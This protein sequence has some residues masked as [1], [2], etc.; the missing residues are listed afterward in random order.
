MPYGGPEHGTADALAHRSYRTRLARGAYLALSYVVAPL[1]FGFLIWRGIANRAYWERLGERFGYTR[2][3]CAEPSIWVHAVSVGEVQAAAPMV[4]ALR[5]DYPRI[6]FVVSTTT[7]TGAR[8]VADLFGDDVTHVFVP[9]DLPGGVR[10]FFDR[11]R[12]RLAVVIETELWPNL[13]HECG[14]RRVPLVLASARISPRSVGKYQRFTVLFSEALSHGIVIAAQSQADLER[15]VL[16]GAVPAR[17]H[18]TG[19]IKC[20]FEFPERLERAGLEFRRDQTFARPVWVAASTHEGEEAIV[21]DAFTCIRRELPD[22]LLILVPRHPER[23]GVVA[24]LVRAR[25]YSI[26]KRTSGEP[27]AADTD[28]FVVDTLG[29]LPMF[30]AAADVAFVGGSLVPIGGHNLVEPAAI[31][32]PILTG[33]HFFNAQE[34]AELL[35]AA[36]AACQVGNADELASQVVRFLKDENLRADTGRRARRTM[37]ENRGALERLLSLIRPLLEESRRAP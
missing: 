25:G 28:V 21:L 3:R 20:D 35:I 19:N 18:V 16:L 7:P 29:E 2:I 32:C 26:V 22:C 4:R 5:R 36:R 6:P 27:S 30:Y 17:T 24:S 31:G 15:F 12:P 34:I 37:E 9:Y 11:I 8:R 33:P 23:F 10:R 1:V 13:Y 14:S